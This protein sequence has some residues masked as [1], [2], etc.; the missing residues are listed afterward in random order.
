MENKD[1]LLKL[2]E[3]EGEYLE[4]VHFGLT[5]VLKRQTMGALCGYV[6]MPKRHKYYDML[7]NNTD[8]YNKLEYTVHGGLT[9]CGTL[10]D[11]NDLMIG[12]DCAHSGDIM[13]KRLN[14]NCSGSIYRTMEY[15]KEQT[16]YLA[17]QIY[18][19]SFS[20]KIKSVIKK[21]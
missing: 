17:E 18:E 16:K 1:E 21:L 13:P 12:F 8:K 5:C 15:V 19:D 14:L 11:R 20:K 3:Q 9:F 6:T 10:K 7:S 2:I 4:F